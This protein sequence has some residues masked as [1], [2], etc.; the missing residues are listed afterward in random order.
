M[1]V[2]MLARELG[3]IK[4]PLPFPLCFIIMAFGD[5]VR[6]GANMEE[7]IIRYTN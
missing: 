5:I 2:K 6:L 1:P 7:I 3:F 4:P